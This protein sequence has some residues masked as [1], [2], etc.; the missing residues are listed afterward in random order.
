MLSG[1]HADALLEVVAVA[2][3]SA[4]AVVPDAVEVPVEAAVASLLVL[5]AELVEV[6]VGSGVEGVEGVDGVGSVWKQTRQ[7]GEGTWPLS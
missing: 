5:I 6:A 1:L 2:L 4:A 7:S 3:E